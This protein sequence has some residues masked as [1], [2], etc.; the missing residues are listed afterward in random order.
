MFFIIYKTTNIINN[1]YYIG[2][3]KTENIE[4]D[5]L[6]SGVALKKAIIKYGA[7]NFIKEILHI[8]NTPEEMYKKEE[9]LVQLNEN[10]YNLR[11]GGK[12]GWDHVDSSGENNCMK[13][14]NVIKKLVETCR[15][16]NS[17]HTKTKINASLRN[18]KK[19]VEYN[20][21][22]KRPEHSLLMMN[23][24]KDKWK[25][26]R[27][28]MRDGLSSYFIVTSPD[29]IKYET[30]RLSDFCIEHNLTYVAL[31]NTSRTGR[32]VKK[33]KSKNWRC[34]KK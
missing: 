29:N 8:F 11:K 28:K 31:W 23:I 20:T 26:N 9:E 3:H 27:E 13:N 24:M 6:G 2:A 1:K 4:D 33:G 10:S 16:N 30:N 25:N 5:Y 21:G 12:G 19:A 14:P 18:L 22:R 17:Y 34:I 32:K 7:D 15:K